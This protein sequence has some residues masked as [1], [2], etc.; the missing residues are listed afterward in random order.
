MFWCYRAAFAVTAVNRWCLSGTPLQN[1]VGELYSLIRFLR[2]E[3]M[4]HYF[5]R[6]KDCGCK[7]LHY[8]M[9]NGICEGC[10]HRAFS[11][12]SHFNKHVL[13]P[14]Q[15][16][17]YS[18]DGRRAM[19]KL[20]NEVLDKCKWL[21]VSMPFSCWYSQWNIVYQVFFAEPRKRKLQT[22]NSPHV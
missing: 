9:K 20:K 18:G 5:C 21:R 11:H 19:F 8:R 14:I 7:S 4:A 22:S 1:R 6:Q 10:G 12:F 2:I 17:G 15:R 16:E 3:P 13:N